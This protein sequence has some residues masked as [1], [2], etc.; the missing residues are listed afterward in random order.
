[1]LSVSALDLFASSLGVFMLL[2]LMLFPYFLKRPAL[3][4]A[5]L[6]ARDALARAEASRSASATE[7]TQAETRRAAAERARAAARQRAAAADA[8]AADAL[9][10]KAAAQARA[11]AVVPAPAPVPATPAKKPGVAIGD[12]DLMLVMDTTGSMRDE[13]ADVQ[14]SL[15]ATLTLLG[16]LTGSLRVGFVA[17][18]DRGEAYVTRVFPLRPAAGDEAGDIVA[19]VR[20]LQ[21][22]GG[23]D[24]PEAVDEALAPAVA[25]AWRPQAEG[26]IILI[27]DA[28]ARPDG[29]ARALALAQSFRASAPS[30]TASRSVATIF[31][32]NTP[33]DREFFRQLAAAGGGDFAQH[34]G[35]VLET[36]MLSLLPKRVGTAVP[37]GTGGPAGPAAAGGGR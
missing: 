19:F 8:A 2:S 37:A 17:Y 6:Q 5:L 16:K 30:P 1:M 25:Q 24:D 13:L 20:A 35:R 23:G 10:R 14:A 7:L 15:L 28:R 36:V 18:K 4:A 12:L 22:G 29:A 11:A 26:R 34:Q 31:T 27:G 32:G 33:A 9:R 21:A 3:D